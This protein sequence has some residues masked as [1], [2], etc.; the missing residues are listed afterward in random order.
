MPNPV[1]RLSVPPLA[2]LEDQ[3]RGSVGGG[4]PPGRVSHTLSSASSSVYGAHPHAFVG[5]YFHQ[6]GRARGGHPCFDCQGCDGACSSSVS[7]LLQPPVCLM[8]DLGV[9]E[10]GHLPV[11]PQPLHG[12]F[13]LPHGDHPV[14]SSVCPSG[15]LDGLHRPSGS[16]S[17]GSCPSRISSLPPLCGAWPLLPVQ[18]AVLV[19]PRPLRSSLGLW[20]LF[21]RFFIP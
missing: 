11:S 3:G 17:A 20:L 21:L 5:P 9:V 7:G 8:K 14:R 2:G 19:C 1:R 12:R 13:T 15:G 16:V 10:T 6:G 4:G 18:S